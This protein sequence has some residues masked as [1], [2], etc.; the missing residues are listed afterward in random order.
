M[1]EQGIVWLWPICT[2]NLH[3]DGSSAYLM[4][5]FWDSVCC[6]KRYCFNNTNIY[7]AY[8]IKRK[9]SNVIH[10]SCKSTYSHIQHLQ[11]QFN[12]KQRLY[13]LQLSP[14]GNI[15]SLPQVHKIQL[16]HRLQVERCLTD[17]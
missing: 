12:H 4:N 3:N 1:C 7:A 5:V 10:K 9:T 6:K 15:S 13:L 14:V 2:S 17:V 16:V 11:T 8:T